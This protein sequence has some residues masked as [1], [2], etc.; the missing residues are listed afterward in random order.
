[1]KKIASGDLDI[2]LD[3]RQNSY[4]G[5]IADALTKT[6]HR[7]DS[8]IKNEYKAVLNRRNAEYM[9][10]QSQINPHFLNN[11]LS[12]F[13]TL[14]RIG[15]RDILE[16]S[17]VNLSHLFRYV[18]N[19][20]NL[21]TVSGE[22]TF[23]EEYLN[24]QKLRFADKLEFELFRAPDAEQVIL[25]KL[26]LQPLVE[27]S[28]THGMEPH[29]NNLKIEVRADIEIRDGKPHLIIVI[30]DNGMGFDTNG[31]G[32]ESVGLANIVERLE[33]FDSR[34]F[35]QITSKPGQG[36]RCEIVLPVDNEDEDDVYEDDDD[37]DFAN[38]DEEET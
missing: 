31:L 1:M 7:L 30:S 12:S 8:H 23:L 25:P 22:M 10:L 18:E 26:L 38:E 2:R 33:L 14:N 36:C 13:I 17:I 9:A 24:L 15:E 32:T 20:V 28:I 21:S 16:K 6:A 11:I 3:I 35:F 27:N 37:T 19:N 5:T 29:G 34:S 4:L